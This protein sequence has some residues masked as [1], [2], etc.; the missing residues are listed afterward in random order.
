MRAKPEKSDDVMVAVTPDWLVEQQVT[1]F[2]VDES[3]SLYRSTRHLGVQHMKIQN[4]VAL[5][6]GGNR[7][8]GKAF[9]DELF[10]RG[11]R[12]VYAAV[13]N[14]ASVTDPRAIAIKLDV[15]DPESAAA[16]ARVASD[17]NLLINNAGVPSKPTSSPQTSRTCGANSRRIST[18]H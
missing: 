2:T 16:A 15:T 18:D 13:R 1:K 9:V 14:P 12:K 5:V 10:A 6:T 11:A 4:S 17:V 8:I 3:R 7:G